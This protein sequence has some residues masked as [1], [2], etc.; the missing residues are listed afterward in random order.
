MISEAPKIFICSTSI[1]VV[2]HFTVIY[3]QKI[4]RIWTLRTCKQSSMIAIPCCSTK[5]KGNVCLPTWAFRQDIIPIPGCKTCDHFFSLPISKTCV[6]L[7]S[8]SDDVIYK[9][10]SGRCCCVG[11]RGQ[12]WTFSHLKRKKKK[13]HNNAKCTNAIEKLN[14]F[15][16]AVTFDGWKFG[17]R[18]LFVYM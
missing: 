8:E 15:G 6:P 13:S 18:Q 10:V 4:R 11:Q 2:Q 7:A 16:I 12:V 1:N 9:N 17:S 14:M 5:K 3:F